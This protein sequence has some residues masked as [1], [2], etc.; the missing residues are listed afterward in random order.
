V[1]RR[2]FI[3]AGRHYSPGDEFNWRQ[4]AISQRKAQLLYDAGKLMHPDQGA[5]ASTSPPAK[6]V[7]TEVGPVQV[8]KPDELDDI[9][10]MT[11]LRDIARAEGA[12]IKVSKVDQRQ[13]IREHRANVI[14]D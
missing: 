11:A 6:T 4:L 12:P 2:P 13:A 9:N 7:A 14:E 8:R 5:P 1:V 10:D 3:G